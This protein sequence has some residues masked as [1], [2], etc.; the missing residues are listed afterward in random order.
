[1]RPRKDPA[2]SQGEGRD[3]ITIFKVKRKKKKVVEEGGPD[4][5]TVN[6]GGDKLLSEKAEVT[7]CNFFQNGKQTSVQR[8]LPTRV[9]ETE[10]KQ[11]GDR[12]QIGLT[13]AADQ[14][15]KP[16]VRQAWKRGVW[17]LISF[18]RIL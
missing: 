6:R 18:R 4:A 10:V 2:E 15:A 8:K 12:G 13:P 16:S 9:K 5:L 14:G 1:M 17:S 7:M 3:A 11:T